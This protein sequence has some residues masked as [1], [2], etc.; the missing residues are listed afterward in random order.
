[1][2]IEVRTELNSNWLSRLCRRGRP[3]L[4]VA[5]ICAMV[6]VFVLTAGPA[7]AGA[8]SLISGTV[9]SDVA[10]NQT[11]PSSGAIVDAGV[12]VQ[13]L[14]AATD[15]VVATTTTNSS[16]VY[17]FAN[18]PDG[19]YQVQ[20]TAPLNM[21]LPAAVSGSSN[22]FVSTGTP[23]SNTDPYKGVSPTITISG[24]T[25][26]ANQDAGLQ[27]I[28]SLNVQPITQPGYNCANG[29]GM[30][31][32]NTD[33]GSCITST[34]S[35]VSQAFAVSV[36]NLGTG[37][38]VH[39][40]IATFTFTPANGAVLSMPSLPAGCGTSN[41][42]PPSSVS[43]NLTLVCNLGNVNS[44]Q[45]IAVVPVVVPL[46]PSPNGSS[47][48]TSAQVRAGDG[49]AAT[50]DTVTNPVISISG[51]P[52]YATNKSVV[53]NSGPGTYTV[54]GQPQLG[55]EL[56]YLIN[57]YPQTPKGS[58]ELALPLTIPDA[59][60]AQFPGAVVVSCGG[61]SAWYG[62]NYTPVQSCPVGQTASASSPWNFTFTNYAPNGTQCVNLGGI[63]CFNTG[64][65]SYAQQFTVF[66]PAAD[67]NKAVDP[68]WQPGQPAPTGSATF[69]N[70]F[71]AGID[72]KT[73]STG[74]PNNGNGVMAGTHC[75]SSSFTIPAGG[76][77][78][79][80]TAF[81]KY[82]IDGTQTTNGF[83]V[84]P[85]EPN[86]QAFMQYVNGA[87]IPDPNFSMCDYFD[88]STM[89]LK[90]TTPVTVTNLP[91]GFRV[92]YG[93]AP[94][95]T[96]DQVGTPAV[97]S[98]YPHNP[99]YGYSSPDQN[100]IGTN[101]STYTGTWST[102][103]AAAFGPNWQQLVN[104]VSIAPIPGYTPTPAAPAGTTVQMYLNFN[105]LS[106][107]NGGPNAG[108]TILTG[109]Y[110]PNVGSWDRG[111]LDPTFA[112]QTALVYYDQVLPV[113]TVGSKSYF[114]GNPSYG[115]GG[116]FLSGAYNGNNN[117]TIPGATVQAAVGYYNSGPGPDFSFS[118]C[119]YFDVSTLSLNSASMV[120]PTNNGNGLTGSAPPAGYEIEY[121]VAPNTIDDQVGTPTVGN[122]YTAPI[123]GYSNPD[124]VAGA[125]SCGTLSAQ[126]T[127]T[128][129][130]TFGPNWQQ[131]VNV[132]RLAPIPGYTPA[133]SAPPSYQSYLRL[134][135]TTRATYNGGPNAGQTIPQGAYI[136]NVGSW[137]TPQSTASPTT[138]QTATVAFKAYQMAL[139]KSV[140]QSVT[141]QP[142]GQIQWD[143]TP[144][145]T[146]GTAGTSMTGVKVTDPIPA[147]TTYDSACT[148]ANLPNGVTATYNASTNSVTFT[149]TNPF[150]ISATLPQ[151][152]PQ[153]VLCTDILQ[154][155]NPGVAISNAA[156]VVSDQAPSATAS[157]TGSITVSGPGRLALSKSVSSP[158]I[159]SNST[160]S[161]TLTWANTSAVSFG[162]PE[163]IDV[164]PYNNDGSS[165][166]SS[167]RVSGSSTFAGTNALTGPLPQPTYSPGSTDSGAVAGTWYY[168]T[169]APTT[170]QQNPGNAAN[171]NP[172]TGPSI[173]VTAP[174][175]TNFSQVTGVFFVSAAPMNPGDQATV[176]IPMQANNGTQLGDIYVNQAELFSD[177]APNNP[178]VS[179]NPY[180]QIPGL[181]IAKTANPTTI[182]KVGQPVTY[183]FTVGNA[184][185]VSLNNVTVDDTQ[186]APSAAASLGPIGCTTLSSPA[187]TCSGSVVPTLAAGQTATFTAP[188]VATQADVDHGS[189]NDSAVADAVTNPGGTP[190]TS[191]PSTAVVTATQTPG[192]GIV[193]SASPTTITQAG[194]TVTYTYVATNT[195]NVT[196]TGVGV[197]DTQSAPA[198]ALATAPA[199]QSLAD[200]AGGCSGATTTLAPGQAATF[201]ATYVATQADVDHGM[202]NDSAV[203]KGTP[204]TP[205]GGQT[206]PSITSTP[207]P[208]VVTATQSPSISIVKS[209]SSPAGPVSKV[210]DSITYSFAVTNTGNVTLTSVGVNDTQIAPAGA[211]ASGPTCRSLA[212]PAG[213]CS[214]ATAT[215]APGQVATFTAT[216][217]VTQADLDNGSVNDS[218]TASGTPP[219]G[220][221]VTSTPS[222]TSVPVAQS[223]SIS[224]VKSAAPGTVHAA[225]DVISYSF[226]VTN[227][228]NVTLHGITVADTQLPPASQG[229][230]SA[231][232][233]LAA[234]LAAGASTT[235]TG[236]YTVTQADIDHGKVDDTAT[237]TGTPPSGPL[238]TSPPSAAS[239]TAAAAPGVSVV[240]S[241]SASDVAH[242]L[243]GQAITYTFVVTNTGN[244]TLAPVTV[245]DT[246]FTGTG[247]LSAVSCPPGGTG[248]I[249]SLAPGAQ[250]ICTATYTVTT[251]DVDAG[252]LADTGVVTGTPPSGPPVTAH[253]PLDLPQAQSPAITVVKSAAPAQ[254]HQAG[255]V[256]T[257]SYLVTNTGNTTLT[258]VAVTDAQAA[259]AGPLDG[260]VSCPDTTLAPG[261][262]TT[263][264]GSYTVIQAD[265]DHGKVD[266]TAT[267]T[268]TP[269]SGPP[270]TSPPSAVSVPAPTAAALSVVKS[271]PS[272]DVRAA[273]DVIGYQFLVTN[274]GNT[275]L[276]SVTV[277]DVQAAP[278]GPL[279]GPVT[280]PVTTLTPGQSVTCTAAYTVT[281]ADIDNG[282]VDD[283]ATATGTPP[284]GPP[285]TSPPSTASVPAPQAPAIAI[286]KS[287][288]PGQV[289]QAGDVVT[290]R[291]TVT[292]TGNTTLTS[293]TVSDAQA[294][295]AGPLDGPVTCPVTTLTPEES[296][297]CAAAYTVTQADID[298]GKVDDTAT[299][300]GTPPSG[301]SAT[302]EPVDVSV[303]AQPAPAL[304]VVKSAAPA[305]VHK[306][307]D[308]ISYSFLVTNTGNV[309]MTSVAVT[310]AQAPP[311]GALDGPVTCPDTT[312]APGTSTTC[313]AA[314]TVTQ[315]DIDNGSV[316]DT[317][318]ATGTPPSGPAVTSPPSTA[319]VAA[320]QAP[321]I[322]EA[323]STTTTTV[324]HAGQ[325]IPYKFLVTN[326]GNLTLHDVTVSDVVAP[327]SD[328]AGL[329][330]VTCPDAS[331][332][333]GESET[334]TATYTATQA[335][336]DH[337]GPVRDSATVTGTPPATPGDPHP[338]PLP[339][340]PPSPATVPV[341]QAPGLRIVK[342][343]AT[344]QV[345]G[346]PS[347]V[348][349]Y[350]FTL[351]N[352]GNVTLT[353]VG[354]SDPLLATEGIT[355][356]CPR[357]SLAPGESQTCTSSKPYTVTKADAARGSVTNT[358][359]AHARTPSGQLVR[360]APSTVTVT[361]SPL[362]I[363]IPT[364]QGAS[365]AA[366]GPSPAL[367]AGAAALAAGLLLL[368]AR[369]RRRRRA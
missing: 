277:T 344:E 43:G 139:A 275:T 20:V 2:V 241:A 348:I 211:L 239:V 34:L 266:D 114:S 365:A 317:A 257:Y 282:S 246:G 120:F 254:V 343:A 214:G 44:A 126:F 19:S 264:T 213:A 313:T 309:T 274:T 154:T 320:Q 177:T 295:P 311:A 361:V 242:L 36:S 314:Y 330:P 210:G 142:G 338:V 276:T 249:A 63:V 112:N 307:G 82:D 352:T 237:A 359:D 299:A 369:G 132:V 290:Y 70:C 192:I 59:G 278:A 53:S 367:A 41:V 134:V 77:P 300:T 179:N 298:H 7:S 42:T 149:Y 5:V 285:A 73:D 172:G 26:V 164:L 88:V 252:H 350:Q 138:T 58:T 91:P 273:G 243:A 22:V 224:I 98:A 333:P 321:A 96:N 268:G 349:R 72:G 263:C 124:Q 253:S 327:P 140:N 105:V 144:S 45:V 368:R 66:V 103:P 171:S 325:R 335:D 131:V 205:P 155:V 196:L 54:N 248:T 347:E 340:S 62:Q 160:Y 47:F 35:N 102:N 339:P 181:T 324:T 117:Y 323:K 127:T 247:T 293:V 272:A 1:M 84:G 193:K 204:P 79:P 345:T 135:L 125:Q 265:I 11:L 354:V 346:D 207:S 316:D 37:Q 329:S 153:L 90:A 78:S 180:T 228:G 64:T 358:A 182:T 38:T 163:I 156:S 118:M 48:T 128:P 51:A 57:G 86:V 109:A 13:L 212:T 296:V 185:K 306:A 113:N 187:G 17:S 29:T 170:I 281:Q 194:Q 219:S 364:G 209:V 222:T 261:Q 169:A 119:D 229:G 310:D 356:R 165:G 280:C 360:S 291:F 158:V 256:I 30:E 223:P 225:G 186:T 68:S 89:E 15:A 287:A 341:A 357:A 178:V 123:Y 10:L 250:A 184:G 14:D 12:T 270:V 244:V 76:F 95:T 9:W 55:Y 168:T 353:G 166:A 202:I 56:T 260:P 232:S 94:N 236:T 92:Q 319:S 85:N 67:M 40:V 143:L 351:A 305:Q 80:I 188:Y 101:C 191:T 31:V 6:S 39:N 167:Q 312:L 279:D 24:A 258:S 245:T 336:V 199:C 159:T 69:Q 332:A 130:A 303:P 221:P 288:T 328:P 283:T 107:Y 151:N 284:S 206:P 197:A 174:S 18:V 136:P 175:I 297:T 46:G 322:T 318:T 240:K 190:V 110:I 147:N 262:F 145:I 227:T 100:S 271:A 4:V 52:D 238:V 146:A 21:K 292:N 108:Q 50:S 81:K 331:L 104:I 234:T 161:W 16:G 32:A 83:F 216:Y 93:V 235:C 97:S 251:A 267:A 8:G 215:L 157:N 75:A 152:M 61:P 304:S 71:G 315:A 183:T 218:A 28:A 294:A 363:L 226:A 203:A 195:G 121:G 129:A 74:Q 308:V 23:P 259:P 326:T 148:N 87:S 220:T 150:P 342:T 176:P 115:S 355:V 3:A 27:P 233:C 269:P 334:C 141:Y 137:D 65:D 362:A 337:G 301:P 25:Q 133:P 49:T 173:W 33:Q 208:T 201:T 200:P 255:D 230:L 217:T 366:A 99:V 116:G 60:I 162:T 231:V 106:T 111:P 302:S 198:G 189:I 286:V 122:G 289:H